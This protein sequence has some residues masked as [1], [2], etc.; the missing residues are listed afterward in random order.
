MFRILAALIFLA[1]S[2]GFGNALDMNVK[3]NNSEKLAY[4]NMW[5]EIISGDDEK[6]RQMILPVLREG[7]AVYQ[8]NIFSIGG[9]VGAAAALGRQIRTLQTRT[10][11]PLKDAPI[12]NN[13]KVFTNTPVC[14]FKEGNGFVVYPQFVK[15][16]S[17]CTCTSACFLVWAGG[18]VREGSVI[19]I[20]RI[21]WKGSEF[22][23]LP[24]AA[25]K[26]QY[27]QAQAE[28]TAYLKELNVPTTIME[29]MFATDSHSMYFL[30]WPEV[31][32]MESTPY[33][34]EM[35]YSRCGV[36]HTEKMS[37]A[38]N[39]TMTQDIKHVECYKGILTEIMREGARN[40]LAAY[41]AGGPVQKE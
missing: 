41:G 32:L 9:N 22:G 39:W 3:T 1:M 15:G 18:L 4:V 10:T 23:N 25:A 11:A 19:G 30:T 13:Q 8:V 27:D 26:A 40:Y 14:A 38:N 28:E 2:P 21:Y 6:F 34:E 31:Q 7:F 37:A 17:W 29:R 35:T 20:H 36:S 12:I 16:K 33:V 5:G 24:A